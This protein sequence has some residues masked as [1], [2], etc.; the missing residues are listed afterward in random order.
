MKRWLD[1]LFRRP[2]PPQESAAQPDIVVRKTT[3]L[4]EEEWVAETLAS[5][6]IQRI[7]TIYGVRVQLKKELEMQGITN[8]RELDEGLQ[9]QNLSLNG[10]EEQALR[11]ELEEMKTFFGDAY[12]KHF[13]F[14]KS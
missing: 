2:S 5:V 8:F 11:K 7:I 4:T 10:F 6:P 12:H 9:Q 13:E 14:V 1:L 3:H